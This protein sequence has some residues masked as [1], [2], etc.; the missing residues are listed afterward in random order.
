MP[1]APRPR[2]P[3]LS[4]RTVY[5][6]RVFHIVRERVCLPGRRRPADYFVHCGADW[7][8]VLPRTARGRW[9]LIRQYRHG[10]RR[11]LYEFPAGLIDP[12]DRTPAAAAARELLEETGYRG[13]RTRLLGAVYPNPGLQANQ[14]YCYLIDGVR[15][16]APPALEPM[17]E[18]EV[19]EV[20]PRQ[21]IH[22]LRQGQ[23]RHA[24]MHSLLLLYLLQSK[25]SPA[26]VR[27]TASSRQRRRKGKKESLR[28]DKK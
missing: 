23:L 2:W 25:D 5:R 4:R 26:L 16:V 9:L 15:R 21:V 24:L 7:V 18:I 14:L 6:D 22:L 20:S 17:E 12:T 27:K 8:T 11:V 3:I 1:S 10:V 13:R 28:K 19:C